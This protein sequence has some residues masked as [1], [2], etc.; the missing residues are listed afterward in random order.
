MKTYIGVYV[1]IKIKI[2][3]RNVYKT[4]LKNT[5]EAVFL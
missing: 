1:H 3:K 5:R 2:N 4:E